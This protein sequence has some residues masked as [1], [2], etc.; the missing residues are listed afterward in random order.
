MAEVIKSSTANG[1]LAQGS[2][3]NDSEHEKIS[4]QGGASVVCPRPVETEMFTLVRAIAKQSLD[5]CAYQ[6][7]LVRNLL[8][9]KSFP[10]NVL[11]Q[12]CKTGRKK[13]LE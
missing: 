3:E 7:V 5:R 11:L 10:L 12:T 13:S 2:R 1:S 8:F 6:L 4:E 9:P